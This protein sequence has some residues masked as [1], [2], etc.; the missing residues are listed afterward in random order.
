MWLRYVAQVLA[1]VVVLVAAAG[2]SLAQ[3]PAP[4]DVWAP[5]MAKIHDQGTLN[6]RI[7]A[8]A[9]YFEVFYDSEI[10]DAAWAD[11]GEPYAVHTGD[12]IRIH[13][14][15]ATPLFGGPYPG[16]VI[17]HGH[18]GRG[19]PELAMALAALG[20]V[21]LSIDGPR[22][23]QSTGGPEDTEQA[24]ISVEKAMNQPSPEVGF[25]YHYAYAGMRGL[26]LLQYL[27]NLR[28]P[29]RNPLRIDPSRLGVMGAS[30][31]GQFT[32]YINGV[33]SRVKG[34][35]AIAVAGDWHKLIGYEGAW[36]Y[37]GLYYYTRDGLQSR[38]DDL[39]TISDA[40]NFSVDP[41][42]QTFL[43]YFDPISYAP[44]QHGPLLTI[45]GTHDQYFTVPA[46]NTT[47]DR[48][49]SAGTHPWFRKNILM[50]P[51]GKHGVLREGDDYETLLRVIADVHGW[52]R[53]AFYGAA[54]PPGTPAATMAVEGGE[55]VFRAAVVP[56]SR[57]IRSVDLWYATQI[58]TTP[59]LVDDFAPIRLQWDGSGYVG[60][61]AMGTFPPRGLAAT[62]D[63]I[64]YFVRVTDEANF[65]VTSKLYYADHEMKFGD[66]VPVIEHFPR[67]TLP[68]P[69]APACSSAVAATAAAP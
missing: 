62:P 24:W 28:F 32:Y 22:A 51:N 43:D 12:T 11:S 42:I 25:L 67:D 34:A 37:H 46:I 61:L 18:H 10:R 16:I 27:A 29:Y 15:L 59:D 5:V 58:D 55:M 33:D 14:Y 53:H 21:A 1:F 38:H 23:G 8:R 48:I 35:V 20:Y 64:V 56:G 68:V 17:G 63:N 2:V 69:P 47:Y 39:N 3:S 49:K 40:C 13:G 26:T 60:R 41:T 50:T 19:S 9:G 36:L 4:L 31:G 6:L 45:I 7:I 66:I 57:A 54:T 65:T 44:T 52:F 30:M